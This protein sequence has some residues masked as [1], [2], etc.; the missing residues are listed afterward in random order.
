[1][2]VHQKYSMPCH[3]ALFS[4]M[5]VIN[6][7]CILQ[8]LNDRSGNIAISRWPFPT[9]PSEREKN[10]NLTLTDF[11][12]ICCQRQVDSDQIFTFP[13]ILAGIAIGPINELIGIADHG[14]KMT[15]A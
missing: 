6:V 1:M 3:N 8:V 15:A 5:I 12:I 2:L 4:S 9:S 13:Q 11:E 10:T 7:P 14:L